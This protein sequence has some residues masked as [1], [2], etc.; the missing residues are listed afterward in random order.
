MRGFIVTARPRRNGR[1]ARRV[2]LAFLVPLALSGCK[3]FPNDIAGTMDGVTSTGI[4]HAG[5]VA[6]GPAE[7]DERDLARTIAEAAG[8]EAEFQSASAE[9]LLRELEEGDLDI[10]LGKFAKASPWTARVALTSAPAAEGTPPPDEP[11][12]RAAIRH[13]ENRW[14]MFVSET[15]EGRA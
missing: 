15:V 12:L 14:L 3:G 13:G 1:F 7:A 9:V 2:F 11:V 5:I 6:D 4:L 8:A 10:V